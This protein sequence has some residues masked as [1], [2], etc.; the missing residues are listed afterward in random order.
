MFV[1]TNIEIKILSCVIA[2]LLAFRAGLWI[3][4]TMDHEEFESICTKSLDYLFTWLRLDQVQL[5]TKVKDSD[6]VQNVY[7]Q[8]RKH[9][10]NPNYFLFIKKAKTP[11]MRPLSGI[12][13]E[14]AHLAHLQTPLFYF[15]NGR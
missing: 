12:S 10:L 15:H 3:Y 5:P 1:G 13:F 4:Y 8:M 11:Q 6:W 14:K 7:V 9:R 2:V